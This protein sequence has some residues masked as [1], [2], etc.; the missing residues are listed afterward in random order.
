MGNETTVVVSVDATGYSA[1]LDKGRA[2]ATSFMASQDAMAARVAATQA[3][4]AEAATNGSTASTRAINSFI[5]SLAKMA[6][7]SGKTRVELLQQ[8][9]ALLGISNAAAPYLAQMNASAATTKAAGS[10]LSGLGAEAAEAAGHTASFSLATSGAR[11]ELLVLAHEASQ[12]NWKRFGGSLLVLGERMDAMSVIMSP[13]GAGFG[14]IALAAGAFFYEL[15]QGEEQITAFNKAITSTNGFIGLSAA[16]MA[17]M[18]N[19]MQTAT[20]SLSVVREAMAQVAATGTVTADQLQL[21]TQAAIS[22]SQDI[23][24]GTDKAAESLS[25]IQ[26]N[27]I[28]WLTDYQTA[29]HTFNAAQ[30]EEIEGFVK[31]GDTTG[32][33]ESILRDLNAAHAAA[34]KSGLQTT[35]SVAQGWRDIV[36]QVKEYAGM[37]ANI[38]AP[39]SADKQVGDQYARLEQAQ[40]A[41]AMAQAAGNQGGNSAQIMAAAQFQVDA[42][43]KKLDILRQAQGIQNTAQRAKEASAKSGD[44]AVRGNAYVNDTKYASPADKHKLDLDADNQKF[45]QDTK[46]LDKNSALYQAALKRH[47]DNVAQINAQYAKKTKG[48]SNTGSVNAQLAALVS[49]N[50]AIEQEEKRA[51]TAKKAERAA[52]LITADEYLKDVYSIQYDAYTKEI[53][54]AQQRADIASGKKEKAAMETALGDVAKLTAS[55]TAL[56]QSAADAEATITA[57]R[58]GRYPEVLGAARSRHR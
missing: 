21:A 15:V 36:A 6:D 28:K 32:A 23:G 11:R 29:H 7:Q 55:R 44:A 33:Y 46:D 52:G 5:T 19:G 49:R 10:A 35:S 57:K 3:A 18:S 34:E 47:Y 2:S 26:E 53:A 14:A 50:A 45:Q 41:L 24:I 27:V 48:P 30:V 17:D 42:E 20:Q 37:I 56:M 54:I 1:A 13:V 8:K 16:Q 22:M 43:Q 9:A 51:E 40:K 38:A 4:I 31:L 39:K 58:A 12:G 25:K